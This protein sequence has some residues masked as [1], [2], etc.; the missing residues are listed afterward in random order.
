MWAIER[1]GTCRKLAKL[2]PA[3]WQAAADDLAHSRSRRQISEI[4][5]HMCFTAPTGKEAIAKVASTAER[6]AR[7]AVT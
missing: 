5:S 6:A 4:A 1:Q 2:S 3:D 7:R